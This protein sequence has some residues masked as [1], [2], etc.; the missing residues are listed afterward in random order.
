MNIKSNI[1]IK[2]NIKMKMNKDTDT[3]SFTNAVKDM[4]TGLT[5]LCTVSLHFTC[6]FLFVSF[7]F[8]IL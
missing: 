2:M 3:D 1:K 7:S 4:D 8:L 6:F 5:L